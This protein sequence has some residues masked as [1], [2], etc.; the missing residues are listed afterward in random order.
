MDN[1]KN[2]PDFTLLSNSKIMKGEAKALVLCVGDLT[3][4]ARKRT[5]DQLILEE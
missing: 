1:H 4:L 2:N 5:K 3:Y